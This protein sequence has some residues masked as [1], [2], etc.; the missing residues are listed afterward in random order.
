MS[1][2]TDFPRTLGT[3]DKIILKTVKTLLLLFLRLRE[4]Q[5]WLKR[6]GTV[7]LQT[8]GTSRAGGMITVHRL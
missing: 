7:T 4:H 5:G 1:H 8:D 2:A 6:K 3:D